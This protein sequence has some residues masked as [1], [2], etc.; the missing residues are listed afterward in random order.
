M[1]MDITIIR[2]RAKQIPFFIEI[3]SFQ[4]F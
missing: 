2:L 4:A 3:A 1:P